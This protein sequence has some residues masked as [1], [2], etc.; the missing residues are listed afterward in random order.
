MEKGHYAISV[1]VAEHALLPAL[2]TAPAGAG[3]GQVLQDQARGGSDSASQT[4][5]MRPDAMRY[6]WLR[7]HDNADMLEYQRD[8]RQPRNDED[9]HAFREHEHA[10]V[11]SRPR[12]GTLRALSR[13]PA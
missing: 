6:R 4:G 8:L 2:R 1:A 5:S 11:R 3:R 9:S 13:R 10:A 7:E 12:S